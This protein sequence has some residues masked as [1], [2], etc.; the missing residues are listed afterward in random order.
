M[1]E[2]LGRGTYAAVEGPAGGGLR[3][4]VEQWS[5][6]G[7]AEPRKGGD[8]KGGACTPACRPN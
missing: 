4:V 2:N 7:P 6:L 5:G 8:A 1:G 3:N